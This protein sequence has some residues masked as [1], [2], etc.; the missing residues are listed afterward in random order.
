M[1]KDYT[2]NIRKLCSIGELLAKLGIPLVV[3]MSILAIKVN[4][5]WFFIV[6]AYLFLLLF[7]AV[8]IIFMIRVNSKNIQVKEI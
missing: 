8:Y 2:S 3:M 7:L 4:I 6:I 5:L 1:K